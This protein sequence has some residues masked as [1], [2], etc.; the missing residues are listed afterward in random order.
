M[1]ERPPSTMP[2]WMKLLFLIFIGYVLYV[3]NFTSGTAPVAAPI[4]QAVP[5]DAG[6]TIPKPAEAASSAEN[7]SELSNFLDAG[8]WRRAINPNYAGAPSIK[9]LQRGNGSVAGCGS[10]VSVHYRGTMANGANFDTSH[11]ERQVKSF[12]LGQAPIAAMNE[13]LIGMQ[14]GG[15]RQLKAG[16]QQ[17]FPNASKT[18]DSVLFRIEMEALSP[19]SPVETLPFAMMQVKAAANDAGLWPFPGRFAND[20]KND[21]RYGGEGGNLAHVGPFCRHESRRGHRQYL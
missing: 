10:R 12:V 5:K 19:V 4:Q 2:G 11:D 20:S 13:G 3:G 16:Q 18:L 1:A 7:Y 8:R 14:A 6:P 17:V 21:C 9:E 15:V